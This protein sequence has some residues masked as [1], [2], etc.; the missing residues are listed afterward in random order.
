MRSAEVKRETAE[1]KIGVSL[2]LDGSGSFEGA[3]GIGFFD[4]MLNLFACHGGMDLKIS[5]QGDLEIDNHHT[6]EDLGIVL[7]EALAQAL[8]DKKGINRYGCFYCPMDEALTRVVIDLSGRPYLV[9]DVPLKVER[10]GTFETEMLKEF[11]YAFAVNARMN[12]HVANFY[13][14]NAHHIVESVF[15]ALGHALKEAVA[16]N[17]SGV[18]STKGVL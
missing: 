12:L 6:L 2:K 3:T 14:D 9:C 4:H 11:L 7:G 13:G 16:V 17:G 10:I 8:G 18:L 1:T 15:K 5:V